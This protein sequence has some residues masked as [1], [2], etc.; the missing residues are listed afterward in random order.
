MASLLGECGECMALFT[1]MVSH[2]IG[3]SGE[4]FNSA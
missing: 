1:I 4:M 3:K 2:L